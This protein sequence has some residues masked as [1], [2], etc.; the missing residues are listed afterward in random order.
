VHAHTHTLAHTRRH[1][2]IYTHACTHTHTRTHSHSMCRERPGPYRSRAAGPQLL[3]P[4]AATQHT[5]L[6]PPTQLHPRGQQLALRYFN[7]HTHKH[8]HTCTHTHA[9]MHTHTYSHKASSTL[10]TFVI[11]STS[12]VASMAAPLLT[13]HLP[14]QLHLRGQP[15]QQ[16]A[17]SFLRAHIKPAAYAQEHSQIGIRGSRPYHQC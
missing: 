9:H 12:P 5:V 7:R 13:E 14:T 10:N 4:M 8:T 6:H 3:V 2:Y 16:P 11:A 1:T 15:G 17:L